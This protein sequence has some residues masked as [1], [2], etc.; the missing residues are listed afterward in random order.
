M[1]LAKVKE[2]KIFK[3]IGSVKAAFVLFL[4]IIL[5]SLIG[6]IVPEEYRAA[7]YYSWWFFLLLV[8]FGI[9]LLF[10][11]L[12]R[13]V[14]CP[15]KWGSNITH[16][17]VLV[18][19]AGSLISFFWGVRGP[20]ELEEGQTADSFV[21]Q[22]GPVALNFRVLLEDFNLEWYGPQQFK[23]KFYAQDK[24]IRGQ[25]QV[26]PEKEKEYRIKGTDYSFSVLRYYP[27][28]AMDE[29]KKAIN[30]SLVPNNPAIL[31]AINSPKGR[32]ERWVFAKHPEVHFGKDQNIKFLFDWEPMI[33]EFRSTVKFID[34]DKQIVKTIKVN[35]P[36]EYKGYTFYQ[37]GYDEK[38]PNWTTLEVVKDPGVTVV[39]IG[40]ILLNL[41]II[42]VYLQKIKTTR[43][44]KTPEGV[45][46]Q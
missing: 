30:K 41:G 24:N 22:R 33:K 36:A 27:D 13:L 15:K 1:C 40:F 16:L 2:D 45:R 11:S 42:L 9:N 14:S 8:L 34:T 5:V 10:C 17:S 12:A 4:L 21:S 6:A 26:V 37:L 25:Y 7:I 29:E 31:L 46:C 39:F 38:K 18:I 43:K 28:F 32:E 44:K 20:I 35:S 3:F 23:I 19:L